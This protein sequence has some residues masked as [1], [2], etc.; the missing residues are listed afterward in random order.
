MNYDY[1]FHIT[2]INEVRAFFIYLINERHCNFHPD[3]DF[4]EYTYNADGSHM[5]SQEEI[6]LFNRLMDECFA[7]C[8]DCNESIYDIGLEVLKKRIGQQGY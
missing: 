5:F 2:S 7:V 6:N 4:S 3:D 8:A 1:Y